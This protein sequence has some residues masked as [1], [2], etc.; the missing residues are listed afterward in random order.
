MTRRPILLF[1]FSIWNVTFD[2]PRRN[3][4]TLHE[5]RAVLTYAPPRI[6]LVAEERGLLSPTVGEDWIQEVKKK[7]GAKGEGGRNHL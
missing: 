4:D 7:N 5:A 1:C 2:S 3:T 6:S